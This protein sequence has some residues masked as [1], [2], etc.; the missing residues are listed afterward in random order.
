MSGGSFN[1]LCDAGNLEELARK[2]DDLTDMGRALFEYAP[3][4]PATARTVALVKL[5][6]ETRIDNSLRDVW[7]AME[8][9]KS[10]DWSE[11]DLK[12]ALAEFEVK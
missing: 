6:S 5:I 7:E 1:Y 9:W 8:W 10:C 2:A 12:N 11:D 3:D 4:H